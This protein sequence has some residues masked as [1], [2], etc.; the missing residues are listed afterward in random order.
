MRIEKSGDEAE[1]QMNEIYTCFVSGAKFGI[2]VA[3]LTLL[4][5]LIFH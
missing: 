3:T 2:V 5:D 4:V 1:V